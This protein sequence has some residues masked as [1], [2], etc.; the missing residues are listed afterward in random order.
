MTAQAATIEQLLNKHRELIEAEFKRIAVEEERLK[1]ARQAAEA[2]R[3][4]AAA[5]EQLL[6]RVGELTE[7]ID[8]LIQMVSA[9]VRQYPL[10]EAVRE[11]TDEVRNGVGRIE[12]NIQLVLAVNQFVLPH[13]VSNNSAERKKLAAQIEKAMQQPHL[14]SVRRQLMTHQRSLDVFEEQAAKYGTDVPVSII[15]GIDETR[16]KIEQLEQQLND[17]CA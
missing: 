17:G 9:L 6:A 7:R 14:E 13:V 3:R 2:E 15:N 1:E 4:R 5:V 12:D 8:Q 16:A 10:S 11:L